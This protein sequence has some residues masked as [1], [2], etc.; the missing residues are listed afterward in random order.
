MVV[1]YRRI[2]KSKVLGKCQLDIKHTVF[3][4][5][6]IGQVLGFES[7]RRELRGRRVIRIVTM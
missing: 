1:L 6:C 2:E 4:G 7:I 3:E 5:E